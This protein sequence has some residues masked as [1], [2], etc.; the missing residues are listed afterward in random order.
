MKSNLCRWTA[1]GML[2]LVS[3]AAYSQKED[4][5]T[6]AMRDEMQR[7]MKQLQLEGEQKPYFISYKIVDTER[8][9]ARASFGAL[10][11]SSQTRSRTLNVTVRVGDYQFDNTGGSGSTTALASLTALLGGMA[12]LPEDD[13]YDELR[14]KI[15]M[16][17]DV[18][19]KRA[20]QQLSA[21]KAALETRGQ[22]EKIASFSKQTQRQESE[23]LPPATVNMGDAERLVRKASAE[24]RSVPSMEISEAQLVVA[25]TAEH[26]LDSEGTSYVRQIPDVTFS[27]HATLQNATGEKFSDSCEEYGRSLSELPNEAA[28]VDETKAVATAL[29]ARLKGKV[30]KRY[31]GPVLVQG[32]AAAELFANHFA[33]LVTAHRS[34]GG[35]EL[36]ILSALLGG[37]GNSEPASSSFLNKIGSRVLPDYLTVTDNPQLT[38][39][40][41]HPLLGNYKFDEEGVPSQETVLVKDGMLKTLLNSRTPVRGIPESTGSMR[42]HGVLPGNVIVD[43]TKTSSEE[44]L[45]AQMLDM[46]KSRGL[47][48]GYI[49]RK[50]E[51]LTAVEAVRVFP[52]GREELVRDARLAEINASTFK[53]ILAVSKD[54]TVFTKRSTALFAGDLSSYVVPSMLFEDMTV[55][56]VPNQ[57]PK[58]PVVPSPLESQL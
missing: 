48:Y 40:E 27:A 9:E 3:A 47:E 25:N 53:D 31:N 16:A 43:A 21:R 57:S 42:E 6:R 2:A 5:E 51:G 8:T 7:S 50:L 41:S 17:T 12:L 39:E 35:G 32:E 54:R 37:G 28:L 34:S 10:Q 38:K 36:S 44:E 22:E 52:D 24:F 58:L 1:I 26:F 29:S 45:K 55:E 56:H 15:W 30:A 18:A 20:V 23:I 46:V 19:Y 11:G 4:A 49:V 33:T 13:N 14:R